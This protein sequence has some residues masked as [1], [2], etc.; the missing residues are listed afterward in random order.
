MGQ[1]GWVTPWAI[2]DRSLTKY[3]IAQE[4]GLGPSWEFPNSQGVMLMDT[5]ALTLPTAEAVTVDNVAESITPTLIAGLTKVVTIS[6]F[7]GAADDLALIVA[8]AAWIG[9]FIILKMAGAGTITVK[10]SANIVMA[11]D[12]T[13]DATADRA[14]FECTAVNTWV[15]HYNVSNA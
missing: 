14:V 3:I 10:K 5:T 1:P 12:I 8:P 11:S 2:Y 4:D 6:G 7:G 13:L 15:K 9:K